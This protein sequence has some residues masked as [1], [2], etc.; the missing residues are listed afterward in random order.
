[1]EQVMD[2]SAYF[3]E[4]E[5]STVSTD[6]DPEAILLRAEDAEMLRD[7]LGELPAEFR[8]GGSIWR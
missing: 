5:H 7:A 2:Q 4:E 1:M 6:L 3:D 8:E